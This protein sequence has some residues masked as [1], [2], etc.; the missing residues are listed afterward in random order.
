MSSPPV[1]DGEVGGAD[2]LLAMQKLDG[3]YT[4]AQ[5]SRGTGMSRHC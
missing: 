2:L 5:Q 1:A 4:P 3:Q